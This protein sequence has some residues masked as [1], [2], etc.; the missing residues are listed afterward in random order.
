M[1]TSGS[2]AAHGV[3]DTVAC[4][5]NSIGAANRTFVRKV[6]RRLDAER[7]AAV[8][9]YNGS[10][11]ELLTWARERGS[12]AILDRTIGDWRAYNE[13]M[14]GVYAAYSEYFPSFG[15]R[16][17]DE[18]IAREEAEYDLADAVVVGSEFCAQTLRANASAPAKFAERVHVLKYCYDERLFGQLPPPNL[19][20]RGPVRFL[21]LGP[22]GPRKGFHLILK[23]FARIPRSAAQLTVVGDM[24]VPPEVFARFAD[25]ID[26]R[27]TVPRSEVPALMRNADVCLFP[28]YFEGAGI[29]LYEALAAGCALIQSRNADIAV[30]PE[31]GLLLP[32]LSEAALYAAVMTAIESPDKLA[33]WRAS[34][35]QASRRYSFMHYR[36][37][38][39]K[40]L[41]QLG[42]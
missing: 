35:Q 7:P 24:Q 18:T 10:A 16:V 6:A 15:Y 34:A 31:T 5:P 13:I 8:W 33:S 41:D 20:R 28:S 4:P 19:D 29:V 3:W 25:R 36:D 30:T 14:D 11:S 32:E 9:A 42:V 27:P 21:F 40:L 22:A 38:I 26:Y 39:E 1:S 23:A 12:T 37:G 17:P 2:N